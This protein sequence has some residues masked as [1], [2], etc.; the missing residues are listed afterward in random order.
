MVVD[1][2]FKIRDTEKDNLCGV[3]RDLYGLGR[4]TAKKFCYRMGSNKNLRFKLPLR[5]LSKRDFKPIIDTLSENFNM[6]EA[7]LKRYRFTQI[8]KLISM[9]A[10]KGTR[11]YYHLPV[12]G[13]RTHTNASSY[14][15]VLKL[16]I[17]LN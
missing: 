3:Y 7:D 8:K 10:Y 6:Y 11:H 15:I 12:R 1:F 14:K 17:S 13:Q 5:E 16:R 4:G 9:K 2:S